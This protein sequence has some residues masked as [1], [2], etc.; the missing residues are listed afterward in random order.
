[1]L[2]FPSRVRGTPAVGY[3]SHCAASDGG[4]EWTSAATNT[5]AADR[6]RRLGMGFSAKSIILRRS[7]AENAEIAEKPT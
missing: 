3:F 5:A 6:I 7:D 2:G 4:A 1:M